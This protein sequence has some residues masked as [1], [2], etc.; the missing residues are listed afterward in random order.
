M[1]SKPCPTEHQ[2]AEVLI[3]WWA[4]A[5]H[6]W[7]L[8]SS[9]LI[10]HCNEGI[11]SLSAAS[12]LKSEGLRPGLPDYQIP[13]AR[14]CYGSLWIELKRL[15]NAK[16]QDTQEAMI[17]MLRRAGNRAEICYGAKAA[18]DLITEYLNS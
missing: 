4:L 6:R 16:V 8:S 5:C 3:K 1:P 10:H 18:I 13:V 7:G 12:R 15:R 11:R 2:E 9:M 17:D 14:G